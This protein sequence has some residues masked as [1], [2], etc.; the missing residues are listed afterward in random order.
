MQRRMANRAVLLGG[1]LALSAACTDADV[2][3][4]L[5]PPDPEPEV[6]DNDLKGSFCTEDPATLI[7]PVKVFFDIDDTGS[8]QNNDANGFR[9]TAMQQLADSAANKQG[10][11]YYWGG[12]KFSSNGY[13]VFTNPRFVKSIPDFKAQVQAARSPGNGNTP[14]TGTLNFTLG[15]MTNDINEDPVKA[16]RTRYVIIFI[17]DGNPQP[18]EPLAQILGAVDTLMGLKDKV[19]GITLHTGYLGGGNPE[20]ETFL[21]A[22]A[23]RG[24]GTYKSFPANQQL[25]LTGFNIE[26][27]RR[28]FTNR[29][30]FLTNR[31]MVPTTDGQRV[32]SDGDGI[33]DQE[34][35]K[36]GTD[37]T[38]PDTDRDGC[39]DLVE[40]R[41]SWDPLVPAS[42]NQQ[43][44]CT[45]EDK[46]A[47]T[48]KDGL[49]DCEEKWIGSDKRNPDSDINVDQKAEG[50]MVPDLWDY[51]YLDSVSISNRGTDKDVDGVLDM[52]ELET[53]TAA[54]TNDQNREHW[55]YK[56]E[57]F[58]KDATN[59]RCFT[60]EV[61]NISLGKTLATQSHAENENLIEVVY[62]QSSLDDPHKNHLFRVAR[63]KVP[64]AEGGATI[65]VQPEQFTE[66]LGMGQ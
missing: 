25:D 63:M 6:K 39:N 24:E 35:R 33:S 46:A 21:K 12:L 23:Q 64:Y 18:P 11:E 1:L 30:F 17:S 2:F 8:M 19:G 40:T 15:E 20:A 54:L 49:S 10:T 57:S 38:N 44:V 34:E 13:F 61:S 28:V 51:I 5:V 55:A 52:T 36:M 58:T 59:P 42:V 47:D 4:P 29:Y 65:R 26:A 62:A 7:F 50:D 45:P 14:Y 3:L 43:C 32:D 9:F 31:S 48:D 16:R 66:I 41:L 27:I 60:F 22:M 37:P 56:Q 53:H